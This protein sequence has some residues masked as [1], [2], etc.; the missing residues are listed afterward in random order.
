MKTIIFG[1]NGVLTESKSN[2]DKEMASLFRKLLENYNVGLITGSSWKQVQS[3][4]VNHLGTEDIDLLNKLYIMPGSG[5]CLYQ[6]YFKY[7]WI[8]VFQS[9]FNSNSE[10]DKIHKIF[11]N[12]LAEDRQPTKTYGK[13]IETKDAQVTFSALG[14]K[15]PLEEKINWDPDASKR[16]RIIKSIVN[17]EPTMTSYD[18][19]IAGLTSINVTPKG[20]SKKYGIEQ[21]IKQLRISKEEIF[22]VG[23]SIFDGGCD[24][25]P[26]EIGLDYLNVSSVEDTKNYIR[27][28]V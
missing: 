4:V 22:Y 15:A 16:F 1:L 9:S 14:V 23:R 26:I 8:P 25:A 7:G 12:Y 10:T 2:L 19:C 24:Y 21:L 6:T 13:Q 11:E 20:V 27:K 5:G 17:K 3:Q 18:I 28:I